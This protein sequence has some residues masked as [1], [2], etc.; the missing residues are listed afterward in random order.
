MG[1]SSIS[2]RPCSLATKLPRL[3]TNDR[4]AGVDE[5]RIFKESYRV[6]RS[7]GKPGILLGKNRL[8]PKLLTADFVHIQGIF[9]LKR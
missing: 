3:F 8:R 4:I 5:E 6:S 7:C 9:M 1:S 2:A